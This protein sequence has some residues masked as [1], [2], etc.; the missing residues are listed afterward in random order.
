MKTEKDL[1]ELIPQL[2]SMILD[3]PEIGD[4][5][6]EDGDGGY[7]EEWAENYANYYQDGWNI[8]VNYRCIGKWDCDP[9]PSYCPSNLNRLGAT[10]EVTGIFASY[11][12]EDT[13]EYKEFS[14]EEIDT[15]WRA[16]DKSLEKI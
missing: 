15:L 11:L 4:S 3:N 12:D 9:G 16:L 1:N 6:S 13:D 14:D 7:E 2:I 10:G 5:Y 8:E